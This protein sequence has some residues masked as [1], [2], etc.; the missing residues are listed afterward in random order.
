MRAMPDLTEQLKMLRVCSECKC[1]PVVSASKG[2]V[3]SICGDS[4][5]DTENGHDVKNE[6]E[7]Y[8]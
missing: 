7:N 4:D 1:K 5:T 6:K 2:I 8:D 3:C